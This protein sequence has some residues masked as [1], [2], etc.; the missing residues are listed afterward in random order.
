MTVSGM[1]LGAELV[2]AKVY[3]EDVI[4]PLN[5]PIYAEGALDVLRGNLASHGCVI[6]PS[7]C[8]PQYLMHT[9]PALVFDDYPSMK[10]AI[11]DENLDVTADHILVLRKAS[12]QVGPGMPE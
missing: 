11:H 2:G 10:E 7:G 9:S 1:T 8:A 6:K 5:N 3:N 4:Q 12:P